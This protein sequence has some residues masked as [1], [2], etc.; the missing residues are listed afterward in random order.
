MLVDM[1]TSTLPPSCTRASERTPED[2]DGCTW[3]SR[4]RRKERGARWAVAG[5]V[6]VVLTGCSGTGGPDDAA[7]GVSEPSTSSETPGPSGGEAA[8]GE[9]FPDVE[10]AEVTASGDGFDVDATISS[11][12]DS[13]DRYADAFRVRGEDG[14]VHG[15]R[16]L[17]HDHASEQPF[18][19]TLN[20]AEIPDDVDEVVVEG[21]D[22]VSGWGG[23]T[24]TVKVPR[25]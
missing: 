10:D 25:G 2:P 22:Q 19:R 3:A 1:S 16:E 4:C 9:K 17:T 11:P 12:Y 20:G 14:A 5:M 8:E 7:A 21:R 6:L 13:P 23:E 18:T 24:V 15:V